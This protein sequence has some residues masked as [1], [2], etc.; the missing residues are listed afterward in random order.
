MNEFII[1]I[2]I[3]HLIPPARVDDFVKYHLANPNVWELYKKK[4]FEALRLRTKFSSAAIFQLIRWD[5]AK[6]SGSDGFKI[7]NNYVPLYARMIAERYPQFKDFF[8]WREIKQVTK[9]VAYEIE[10][11]TVHELN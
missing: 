7:N 5:E 4:A 11:D 9:K 6:K 1:R 8:R 10:T 3:G 2:H